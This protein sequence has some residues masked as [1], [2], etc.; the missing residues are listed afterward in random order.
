MWEHAERDGDG[1]QRDRGA[2]PNRIKTAINPAKARS[3][4]EVRIVL[5]DAIGRDWQCGTTQVDSI[6]PKR[7]GAFYIDADARRRCRL[8]APGDLRLDGTLHRHPDRALCR[9]IS[10]LWRARSRPVVTTITSE[11]DEYPRWSQPQ[12]RRAAC[13]VEID[14][15]NEKINYKVPAFAGKDPRCCG[16]Q[17]G[18]RTAYGFDPSALSDDKKVMPTDRRSRPGGGSH[19]AE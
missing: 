13:G 8:G 5:R 11:G 3:T 17:E 10:R 19:P 7:F 12:R 18:G 1:A 2:G 15:R 14:L 9:A 16:R 6:C 4:A